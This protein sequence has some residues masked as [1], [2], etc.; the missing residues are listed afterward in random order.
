MISSLPTLEVSRLRV[1]PSLRTAS[2]SFLTMRP[3]EVL[4][5]S[6]TTEA[7]AG[8]SSPIDWLACSSTAFSKALPVPSTIA[9]SW[10][11]WA[12]RSKICWTRPFSSSQ[13][14]CNYASLTRYLAYCL[15]TARCY[16][17]RTD[18]ISLS[19]TPFPPFS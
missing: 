15:S 6:A 12:R 19:S 18:P 8:L 5:Q 2:I 4:V 11:S 10:R 1:S 13:R 14:Q 16:N 17:T 7:M 9:P 3:T